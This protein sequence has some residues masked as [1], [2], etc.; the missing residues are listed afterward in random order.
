MSTLL[1]A[2]VPGGI[3]SRGKLIKIASLKDEWYEDVPDP[4]RLLQALRIDRPRADL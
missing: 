3:V 2:I 1:D 4:E